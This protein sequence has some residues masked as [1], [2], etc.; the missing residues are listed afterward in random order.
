MPILSNPRHE[1]FAQELASGKSQT[2]AYETAGFK[3]NRHNAS[4]LITN[5]TIKA[6]VAEL[7]GRITEGVVLTKQWILEQLIDNVKLAKAQPKPD[8]SAANQALALLGKEQ[9]MFVDRGEVTNF[10][11]GVSDKPAT[12]DEWKDEHAEKRPDNPAL[13]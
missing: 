2:E 9:G 13:H 3:H 5:E 8:T 11:Y 1:R 12:P 4:R 6:R 10:N 7:Q